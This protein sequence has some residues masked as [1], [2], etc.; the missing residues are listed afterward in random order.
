ME[1][2]EMI[3]TSQ[4]INDYAKIV[5][6]IF[7]ENEK[8][9]LSRDDVFSETDIAKKIVMILMWGCP[10][11]GRGSNINDILERINDLEMLLS[12]E[13]KRNLTKDESDALIKQL[14]YRI[15]INDWPQ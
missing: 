6:D 7:K 4:L 10:T 11:G 12:Q 9:E 2:R 8:I 14:D 13:N 1:A 5:D 15:I 3:K